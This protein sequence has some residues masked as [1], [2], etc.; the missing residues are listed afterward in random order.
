VAIV[1]DLPFTAGADSADVWAHAGEYALD[2]S[3]GVP[4]DAFSPDGQ[5]GGLPAYRWDVL[6]ASGYAWMRQRARRMAALFDAMR[7]DHVVGLYRTYAHPPGGSPYFSPAD[8]PSQRRQGEAVLRIL[9]QAGARLIAEDLGTIPDFVRASLDAMGVPGCRVLRWERHW[10]SSGQ[11][12]VDPREYPVVSAAMTGTHDTDP[13]A[14]WWETTIEAERE[15][16]LALPLA[17][18]WRAQGTPAGWSQALRDDYLKLAYAAG[19]A[20]LFMP[21]QDV[22]GWRTRVNTPGTVSA[23]NWTWC[24]PWPV[25]EWDAQPEARE[26]ADF[27]RDLAEA[28]GRRPADG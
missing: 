7:V 10:Q 28:S 22:F 12:F 20:E 4:P 25:D 1:G 24:L 21:V 3:V 19:S 2:V 9:G 5:N 23:S 11:P 17:G 13:L 14:V 16:V 18:G 15:A 8:E 27:L 6:A 26:R